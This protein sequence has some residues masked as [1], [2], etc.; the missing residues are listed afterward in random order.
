[1]G[2]GGDGDTIPILSTMIRS[3]T[4]LRGFAQLADTQLSGKNGIGRGFMLFAIVLFALA[5]EPAP[6]LVIGPVERIVMV[7][8]AL[9][10]REGTYGHVESEIL[11]AFP[12]IPMTFRNL[13]W[14][15]DTPAGISRAYFDP[16]EKGFERLVE[17]IAAC[18][19][20]MVIVGYGM[21]DALE[22]TPVEVFR[23]SL[24]R[25]LDH[26]PKSV[27][28]IVLL[29]PI[30]VLGT[31]QGNSLTEDQNERIQTY[32]KDIVAAAEKRNAMVVDLGEPATAGT[33]YAPN[34]IHLNEEGYRWLAD[35]ILTQ[36]FG[37]ERSNRGE[38]HDDLRRL[39]QRK[40]ALY[41]QRYRP[42]NITYLLG[43]RA[44]EQGQNA[45]EI[46]ALD[47]KI[48]ELEKLIETVRAAGH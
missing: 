40:N 12:K 35:E 15:G 24:E 45:K 7:G 22:G 16:P 43:F 21:S 34:G 13:G 18:Q 19:P 42:E 46:E 31:S 47:P 28:K 32:R 17:Q 14:S 11:A 5:A 48:A 9:I 25:L 44:Y 8:D 36:A 29:T 38:A 23:A 1:M 3:L 39:V 6:A 37:L 26:L 20:T 2:G 4:R 33:R 10:E 27:Q 30:S 41:F